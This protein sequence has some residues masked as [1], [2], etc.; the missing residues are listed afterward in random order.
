MSPYESPER[1][2]E[3]WWERLFFSGCQGGCLV[4]IVVLLAV[5]ALVRFV[6]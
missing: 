4:G 6:G 5:F 2:K 3:A 1:P